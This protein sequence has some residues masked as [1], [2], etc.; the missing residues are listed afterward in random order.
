LEIDP[1]A[2]L[3]QA[4]TALDSSVKDGFSFSLGDRL[5]SVELPGPEWKEPLSECLVPAR[6][7]AAQSADIEIRLASRAQL[8]LLPSFPEH[9]VMSTRGRIER[10]CR[11]D[12]MAVVTAPQTL[13]LADLRS[14][15]ALVYCSDPDHLAV[16]ERTSPFRATLG[17]LAPPLGFHMLHSAAV[18]HRGQALLL[19]GKGGSGKSSSALASL[20]PQSRLEFLS[21]DYTLIE[22]SSLTVHPFYG[23]FKVDGK[24]LQR[25]PWLDAFPELGRLEEKHCRSIPARRVASPSRLR[26]IV[27]PDRSW[28]GELEPL[29]RFEAL[30][31]MA[32]NCLLQNPNSSARDLRLL[33]HLCR[34]LPSFKLGL[35]ASPTAAE[36]E[37]RL[38]GVLGSAS[39]LVP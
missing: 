39:E 13:S 7:Q 3:R 28:P 16:W 37:S 33:A 2:F 24:G 20:C 32:P 29:S 27:W 12:F 8:P 5:V 30:V 9:D 1:Q 36:V 38:L 10:L 21:E 22:E 18:G 35:A 31:R 19:V 4:W 17:F 34:Q 15:K 26:A 25:M 23:S 6:C 11:E 14:A